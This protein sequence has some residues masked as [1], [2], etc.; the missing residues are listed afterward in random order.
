MKMLIKGLALVAMFVTGTSN[1][2]VITSY[3]IDNAN[4]TGTGSWSHSYNGTITPISGT[5]ANYTGGN[6]TLNDGVIG[7][8]H[9]NNQLFYYPTDTFPIITLFLDGFYSISEILIRGGDDTNNQIPGALTGLDVTINSI[10]DSF[11]TVATGSVMNRDGILVD[12]LVSVSGSSLDGL[13]TNTIRLSGFN[14]TW[15]NN[16]FSI[17]EIQ[18]TADDGQVPEPTTLALMGLGLAGIGWKRRKVA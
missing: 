15:G 5:I 14:S 10:T 12:D 9:N 1:A 2:I 18:L 11:T 13:I 16:T 7:N 8:Y 6:G 4:V 3:N 17:T